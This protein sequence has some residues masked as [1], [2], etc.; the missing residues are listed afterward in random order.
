MDSLQDFIDQ[1]SSITTDDLNHPDHKN[2]AL[3]LQGRLCDLGL[4]DPVFYG[5]KT[6]PFK[7]VRKGDGL[8]GS[9][10][11]NALFEFC[12]I[13]GEHYVDKLL[14]V[15]LLQKL[16]E[17][18]PAT[19]LPIDLVNRTDDDV[20]TRLAKRILRYLRRKN[21][22]VARSPNMYNIVYVEGMSYN[23]KLNKDKFNEWNDLRAVIRILPGGK[24]DLLINAQATT[25][26]G[27]FY[28]RYPMNSQGAA[29]IAFGQYKAWIDGMH[30]G[31][32]P[33]LIQRGMVRVHRDRNKDGKRSNNDPIDI[34]DWFGINQHSTE[35]NVNPVTV[36]KYSAGCLVGRNYR[37]HLTFLAA[38]K[39]DVRYQLD[40]SYLFVSTVIPGDDL[41]RLEPK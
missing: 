9:S 16:T 3:E 27:R 7:P 19:F 17:A 29:R 32:Q 18:D 23:G 33:A 13:A 37:S 38:V 25:E 5:T 30:Q 21:F 26:P 22:W 2:A 41:A 28:T 36:D 20:P 11:R 10:T 12:R 24:P 4:L 34:G 35:P 15:Q 31:T 1:G 6:T 40:K 8:I 14:T 39:K